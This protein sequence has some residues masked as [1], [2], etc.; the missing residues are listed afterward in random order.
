MT[1]GSHHIR[2][3]N[4]EIKNCY[5]EPVY[6]EGSDSNEILTSFL[7]GSV[8]SPCVNLV[9]G[10]DNNL[11][12]DNEISTCAGAGIQAASPNTGTIIRNNR[13]HDVG[14]TE[15]QTGIVTAGA[16]SPVMINNVVTNNHRGIHLQAGTTNDA[17]VYNNTV[18]GNATQGL[19]IEP[20]A[21]AVVTNNIM[22][23]NTT[24][25]I[26]NNGTGPT[27][28]TNLTTAPPFD[29]AFPGRFHLTAAAT[30]AINTG[31]A[32]PADVPTDYEGVARPQPSGG[33]WDI[34]ASEF[35]GAITEPPPGVAIRMPYWR[36]QGFFWR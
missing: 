21:G 32:L 33:Q 28:T 11:I 4:G 1:A 34:G 36:G 13:I 14:T 9:S 31:T 20:S 35:V 23:A 29:P 8:A 16:T 30:T 27:P 2:F 26:V 18:H 19:Q 12:R 10:S 25:Q 22:A 17:K 24:A 15:G 3:Q 5:Y 6:I 7:H